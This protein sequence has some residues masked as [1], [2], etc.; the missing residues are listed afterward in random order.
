MF[1]GGQVGH[2]TVLYQYHPTRSGEAA[3]HFL[4][5][6]KGYIQ[7]DDYG[8][9]DWRDHVRSVFVEKVARSVFALKA[10]GLEPYAYLRCLFKQLPLVKEQDGY[11]ELL[12]QYIDPDLISACA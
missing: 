9:Y 10:N 7:S 1:C 8:G 12:P 3:L 11:R 4:D 2:P 5:D 6:Y